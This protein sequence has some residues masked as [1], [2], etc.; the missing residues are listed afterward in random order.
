MTSSEDYSSFVASRTSDASS[1]P[2]VGTGRRDSRPMFPSP[3]RIWGRVLRTFDSVLVQPLKTWMR[4]EREISSLRRMDY[5]A[6]R[7]IGINRMDIDAIR[8]GTYKRA[9]S[10]NSE[11][12]VF[13]PE[14]GK[15][16]TQAGHSNLGPPQADGARKLQP[17]L[18][19]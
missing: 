12:I 6:L 9:S 19:K 4:L 7:D 3:F 13:C 14:A 15:P 1:M 17:R 11:R 2:A 18:K 8:A 5:T 16:V 10:D